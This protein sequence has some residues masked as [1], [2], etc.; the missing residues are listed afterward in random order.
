M[1][2]WTLQQYVE[3][4]LNDW[5]PCTCDEAYTKRGLIAPDCDYHN[6]EEIAEI[7]TRMLPSKKHG[8]FDVTEK[9]EAYHDAAC[10]CTLLTAPEWPDEELLKSTSWNNALGMLA[11]H[12][13]KVRN[14]D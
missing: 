14:R 1:T 4:I 8:Q 12:L 2:D 7:I 13:R 9:Q 6:N 10:L 5:F 11:N 3:S